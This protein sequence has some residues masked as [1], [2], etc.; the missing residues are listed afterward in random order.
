MRTLLSLFTILVGACFDPD[1]S[2]IVLL[3]PDGNPCKDGGQGTQDMTMSSRMDLTQSTGCAAGIVGHSVGN[4]AFACP[5]TFGQN[6]APTLCA[7]GWQL[8]TDATKINLTACNSLTEFFIANSPGF[9]AN[10]GSPTME[11]CAQNTGGNQSAWFG[12][13]SSPSH[14]S[15]STTACNGFQLVADCQSGSFLTCAGIVI[16]SVHNNNDND[17][18]L[19]C[20]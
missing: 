3:C 14:V 15:T 19:C 16:E 4:N 17:G 6:E 1:T 5:K 8:C 11:V 20:Q 18:V 2:R 12:C 7:P 9:Y 13:G 10:S